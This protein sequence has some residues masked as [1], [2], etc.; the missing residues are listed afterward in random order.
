MESKDLGLPVLKSAGSFASLKVCTGSDA[1][2]EGK[3]PAHKQANKIYQI[4]KICLKTVHTP[5]P[6]YFK[7]L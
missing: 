2:T 3:E 7:Y 5:A 6:G 1:P 4:K